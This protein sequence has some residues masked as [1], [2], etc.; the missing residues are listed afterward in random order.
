M[1]TDSIIIHCDGCEYRHHEIFVPI[2]IKCRV[3]DEIVTYDHTT[4]WCNQCATIRY[5]EFLPDLAELQFE[6]D[7]RVRPLSAQPVP[8]SADCRF[9]SSKP[10]LRTRWYGGNVKELKN[11]IIWRQARLAPPHCLTCGTADITLVD[12]ESINGS[13]LISKNFRHSCGGALVIDYKDNPG[14]RFCGFKKSVVWMDIGGNR[15]D[16]FKEKDEDAEVYDM[17]EF[18]IAEK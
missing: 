9:G 3:G 14:I 5:I 11:R 17:P 8:K 16:D 15:L 4:A 2:T 10:L 18:L 12:Y 1:S 13:E 6:Y 7:R